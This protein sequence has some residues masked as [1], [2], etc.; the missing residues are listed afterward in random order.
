MTALHLPTAYF[1]AGILYLVMPAAVWLL[2]RKVPT[3]TT[4]LWCIGGVVFGISLV[5][6]GLRTH[7]PDG[8]TYGVA[9]GLLFLGSALRGMALR[10]ELKR[11]IDLAWVLGATILFWAVYEFL[12]LVLDD[13]SLRFI[14]GSGVTAAVLI[15]VALLARQLQQ[16]DQ[17]VSAQWLSWVYMALGGCWACAP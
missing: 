5:L 3:K 13:V 17:S 16:R 4:T 6:L 12:S 1:I 7:L 8:L 2:L 15:W 9:N 11:H 14:W 10:H